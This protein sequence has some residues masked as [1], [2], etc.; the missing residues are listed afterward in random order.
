MANPH[1]PQ[2]YYHDNGQ[3]PTGTISFQAFKQVK[4]GG[5]ISSA[6]KAIK[7]ILSKLSKNYTLQYNI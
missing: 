2:Q 1:K 3:F 4:P 7:C 6:I 5:D